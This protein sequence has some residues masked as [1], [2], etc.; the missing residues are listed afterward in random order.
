[1]LLALVLLLLPTGY[2]TALARGV[3]QTVLRPVLAMQ[4]GATENQARFTDPERLRAERDSLAVYLVGE[5]TLAAENRQLRE[6]LGLR[7]RLPPS[8]L[9]AEVVRVPERGLDGSFLLTA[10]RAKGVIPGAPI[11]TPAGLVGRV[12]EVDERVSTAIDWTN[13]DFR[14]SAM[15]LD[16]QVY[17]IVEP[18]RTASGEQLLALTGVPFHTEL[19]SGTLIV[20]SGR[21]GVFPRGIPIGTVRGDEDAESGW[22]KE[23]LLQPVVS[24][25]AMNHVLVLGGSREALEGEDLLKSWGIEPPPPPDTLPIV[26][27]SD[28]T[29]GAPSAAPGDGSAPAS[30]AAPAA[31]QLLGEPVEPP[32]DTSGAAP[33]QDWLEGEG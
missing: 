24:P 23:Y 32:P 13:R 19:A 9:A 4:Q 3:R 12:L 33:I 16:G 14:A 28:G 6:L 21:G 15:S 29:P 18:R 30:G 2:R 1:M 11:V 20:S 31:P 7:D 26:L 22:R 17:G 27:E 10:G 5:A 8:F 25:A